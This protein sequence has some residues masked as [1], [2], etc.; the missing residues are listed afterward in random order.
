MRRHVIWVC[1]TPHCG[2]SKSLPRG[3]LPSECLRC[4]ERRE[5]MRLKQK[6]RLALDGELT[7]SDLRFLRSLR[8]AAGDKV[9]SRE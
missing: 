7:M 1:E 2:A 8:I 9:V 4:V 6:W 5:K 3:T